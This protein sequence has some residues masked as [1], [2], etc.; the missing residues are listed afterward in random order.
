LNCDWDSE[1]DLGTIVLNMS[2]DDPIGGST[3]YRQDAP[4]EKAMSSNEA[5]VDGTLK[6]DGTLELDRRPDVSPGRVTV[7]LRARYDAPTSSQDWWAFM[8]EARRR[9][10]DAGC[11]FM[12]DAEVNSHVDLLRAE[13]G[14]DEI[15]KQG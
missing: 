7:V 11:Q 8:Q 13:D 12:D 6:A 3:K 14:I 15:L 9:M 1:L 4:R 5:I 2:S 10:E